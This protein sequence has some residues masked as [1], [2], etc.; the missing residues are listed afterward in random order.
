LG[1]GQTLAIIAISASVITAFTLVASAQEG[2]IPSWIKNTAK[3]WV[4]DQV[5]DS[6]FINALQFLIT[7]RIIQIPTQSEDMLK[8]LQVENEQ[9]KVEITSLKS[10]INTLSGQIPD[11]VK[12]GFKEYSSKAYGFSF[13]IPD[14][15][16][17]NLRDENCSLFI[18]EMPKGAGSSLCALTENKM[19]MEDGQELL[20]KI[21]EKKSDTCKNAAINVELDFTC[22][23]FTGRKLDQISMD[24]TPA[25]LISYSEQRVKG[26]ASNIHTFWE[27][28]IPISYRTT[29][30]TLET[31]ERDFTEY[32]EIIDEIISSFKFIKKR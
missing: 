25:Y 10:E 22:S 17:E 7:N 30:F 16:Y 12:I 11:P 18:S 24:G 9:L 32:D 26:G 5:S 1:H 15:W 21:F 6:E 4:E 3:F 31:T 28:Y 27:L 8:E 19:P 29:L 14:G 2:P 20:D 23:K 13:N